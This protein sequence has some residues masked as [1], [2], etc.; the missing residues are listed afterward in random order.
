MINK[1]KNDFVIQ[2]GVLVSYNGVNE[3]VVIPNG[4]TI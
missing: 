4:V 1:N 3:N 2:N